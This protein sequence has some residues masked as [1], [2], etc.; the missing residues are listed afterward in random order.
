MGRRKW[1]FDGVDKERRL[2]VHAAVRR[3][4]TVKD[5]A[6]A[7]LA[8]D[9]ADSVTE[10]EGSR[11]RWASR[12]AAIA[13]FLYLAIELVIALIW[14]D[15]YEI[16]SSATLVLFLYV[17]GHLYAWVAARRFRNNA[18]RSAELNRRL[19]VGVGAAPPR[20]ELP[21]QRPE[22]DPPRD[23]STPTMR[24]Q[25]AAGIGVSLAVIA[26]FAVMPPKYAEGL[27][28]IVTAIFLG[29]GLAKALNADPPLADVERVTLWW[30]VATVAMVFGTAA[31]HQA[32]LGFVA[33]VSTAGLGLFIA[34][35]LYGAAD[36]LSSRVIGVWV[37]R[38]K[39]SAR[40]WRLN[41]LIVAIFAPIWASNLSQ[42]M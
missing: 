19:V 7:A 21:Q 16:P 11:W 35:N 5:P 40:N 9:Y 14:R 38:S 15:R 25:Y 32:N 22:S 20:P 37:L 10:G 28:F 36:R 42:F 31:T 1:V 30:W 27:F 33:A 8:V 41:G 2:R 13:V 26:F 29:A 24:Q 18:R 34:S 4:E 6:D 23:T 17:A 39:L 12:L 3:G